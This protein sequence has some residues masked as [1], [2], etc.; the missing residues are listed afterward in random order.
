MRPVLDCTL[1]ALFACVALLALV[2][3]LEHS[4]YA[5]DG[6]KAKPAPKCCPDGGP[7]PCPDCPCGPDGPGDGKGAPY[8]SAGGR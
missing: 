1:A 5:L 2:F 4:P 3:A 6:W 8:G 7:C